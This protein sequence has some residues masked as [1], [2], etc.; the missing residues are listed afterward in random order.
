MG[1]TRQVIS[2]MLIGAVLGIAVGL[3]P[4]SIQGVHANSCT[5]YFSN[6]EP[7]GTIRVYMVEQSA[8]RTYDFNF[9]V[10]HVLGKEWPNPSPTEAYRAG[11]VAVKMYGWYWVNNGGGNSYNGQCYDVDDTTNYQVF[12]PNTTPPAAVVSAVDATWPWLSRQSGAVFESNYV[13]GTSTCARINGWQ[14]FQ[15]GSVTCANQGKAFR[16]ILSTFYDNLYYPANSS[17]NGA[18]SSAGTELTFWTGSDRCLHE[19]WYASYWSTQT[20]P[21]CSLGSAP[22]VAVT[23]WL[24]LVFWRSNDL[25]LHEA[26]YDQPS[27]LWSTATLGY[28]PMASAPAAA[29]DPSG[30]Q[31]VWWQGTDGSLREAWYSA[32]GAYWSHAT[33]PA[34]GLDSAPTAVYYGSTEFVWWMGSDATLREAWYTSGNWYTATLPEG[35]LASTPAATVDSTCQCVYWKGTDDKLWEAI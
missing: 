7:P 23:S 34:S 8:V 1:S 10:K 30:N 18:V 32:S 4:P 29:T 9:Y 31:F 24:Q 27:G 6:T 17:P 15:N 5:G 25:A 12:D 11:A 26:W 28:G 14:M 13:A 22:T 33:L 19:A 35:S 3:F 16:Q 20:L 2:R 21:Y